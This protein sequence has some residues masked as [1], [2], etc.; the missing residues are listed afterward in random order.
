MSH[1]PTDIQIVLCPEGGFTASAHSVGAISEGETPD[2]AY[3]NL[4]HAIRERRRVAAPYQRSAAVA[5]VPVRRRPLNRPDVG[6]CA[7][8]DMPHVP[9][10]KTRAAI[11]EG[12][13]GGLPSVRGF[14]SL[15]VALNADD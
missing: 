8:P 10:A 12:Q 11:R 14:S 5:D 1:L 9:N 13:R 3:K 2:E 15:L 6:G 7:Y 4:L